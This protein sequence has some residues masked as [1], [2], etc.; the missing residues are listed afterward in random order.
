MS[1]VLL[2]TSEGMCKLIDLDK[3][4]NHSFRGYVFNY[5]IG[6]VLENE[7]I[8][9]VSYQDFL[10]RP[11]ILNNYDSGCVVYDSE[12]SMHKYQDR[13]TEY[14]LACFWDYQNKK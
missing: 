4:S 8:Y 11:E 14:E 7:D 13:L 6:K 12:D 10:S 2:I 3:R 1:K 5:L 9:P